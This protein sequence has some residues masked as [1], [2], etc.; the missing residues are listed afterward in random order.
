MKNDIA[1]TWQAT[2]ET[3]ID[4]PT[5]EACA[6]AASRG[7]VPEQTTAA[8]YLHAMDFSITN[9]AA[10][11]IF[12]F[13]AARMSNK[14]LVGRD[15]LLLIC[16]PK[17]VFN[18]SKTPKQKHNKGSASNPPDQNIETRLITLCPAIHSTI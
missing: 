9:N 8:T 13:A 2:D 18:L 3:P 17:K 5:D 11:V 15:K 6:T 16:A 10:K 7:V 14:N 12:L 4:A 1:Y